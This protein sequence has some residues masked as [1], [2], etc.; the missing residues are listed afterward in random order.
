VTHIER[1]PVDVGRAT[2]QW[3]AYVAALEGAGWDVVEASPA[4]SCPDG[5]FI[6]DTVVVHG[7]RVVVARPGVESRRFEL[8]GAVAAIGELG[9]PTRHIVSP[10][11]LDGGDVLAAGGTVYV[12]TGAR[13]NV[14]GARQ[15]R[16]FLDAP[17]VEVP[18]EGAGFLHLKTAVTA[19]P[20]GS[21]VGCP[22]LVPDGLPDVRTV[23]EPTGAQVV[24]LGGSRLLIAA[25]CPRSAELYSELGYEPIV[26]DISEL[27]KLEGC[28]TCLS[29]LC[30]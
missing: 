6:E 1:H 19:L 8:P 5:V 28:V 10:G 20:D 16:G 3:E 13:S 18:I 11:T 29:V 14:E 17:V 24:L 25:D 2:A 22:P 23:P 4:E 12:G 30:P 21:L 26:V 15:L 7:G 27:Q 9:Y